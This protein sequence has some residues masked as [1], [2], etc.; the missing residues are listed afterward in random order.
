[1][2]NNAEVSSTSGTL[3]KNKYAINIPHCFCHR[4]RQLSAFSS[5]AAVSEYMNGLSFRGLDESFVFQLAMLMGRLCSAGSSG[6]SGLCLTQPTGC[7]ED[8]QGLQKQS[9]RSRTAANMYKISCMTIVCHSKIYL[10]LQ[11]IQEKRNTSF[12]YGL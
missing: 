9:N 8:A 12:N 4:F 7:W 10:H 11:S 1:M 6:R 5:A 2:H 3:R